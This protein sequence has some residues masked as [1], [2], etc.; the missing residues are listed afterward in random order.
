MHRERVQAFA[1]KCQSLF[2][3]PLPS[4]RQGGDRK[5]RDQRRLAVCLR[6]RVAPWLGV[7]TKRSSP[8]SATKRGNRERGTSLFRFCSFRLRQ[9]CRPLLMTLG[10]LQATNTTHMAGDV[11]GP[12]TT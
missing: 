11:T 4:A 1:R 8:A 6:V 9:A 3:P 10:H 12:K 7:A 5:H 2:H